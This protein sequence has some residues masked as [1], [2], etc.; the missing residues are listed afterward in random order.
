MSIQ[1]NNSDQIGRMVEMQPSK[2]I[3]Q[4]ERFRRRRDRF[5][6]VVSPLILL[7][8]W[9][10]VIQLGLL[11]SRL[12]PAP[13]M[14]VGTFY[15]LVASGELWRHLSISLIRI[16]VGF[17]FGAIAGVTVGT[18]MGV[19]PVVGAVLSPIVASV[20]PIPKIAIFPLIMVL[21]GLGEMSKFV[22]VAIAV[23]F[24]MVINTVAGVSNV[25]RIYRDVGRSFRVSRLRS[26]FQITL[27]AAMPM[28][29]AGLRVSAGVSLL[30]L[31]SAE[32][33]GAESGIGFLVWNSWQVFDVRS[34]FVGIIVI[35]FLGWASF[36]LLDAIERVCL[37]WA[38]KNRR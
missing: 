6:T 20:Y 34:M 38:P 18:L 31:V 10:I 36:T 4:A 8:I 22:V 3:G 33:V 29:I 37:P 7:L 12:F 27:P 24:Y 30:V 9:E 1:E 14:I 16:A 23:F 5:L 28:I 26:V 11:D 13:S 17:F 25:D 35:G 32:F 19:M 21:F 2:D 15:D